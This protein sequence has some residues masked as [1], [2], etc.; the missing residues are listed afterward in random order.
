MFGTVAMRSAVLVKKRLSITNG[1]CDLNV[2]E[3][4]I[5]ILEKPIDIAASGTIRMVGNGTAMIR[6]WS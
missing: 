1:V 6:R 4:V 5:A 2:N 3:T